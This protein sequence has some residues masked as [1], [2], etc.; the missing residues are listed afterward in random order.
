MPRLNLK[1]AL[2]LIG[3]STQS[4]P[5]Y[6]YDHDDSNVEA[7]LWG[8]YERVNRTRRVRVRARRCS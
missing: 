4:F 8:T 2:R 7:L 1:D 3:A 6:D 5:E